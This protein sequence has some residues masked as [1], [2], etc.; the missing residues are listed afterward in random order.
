MIFDRENQD[1]NPSTATI[2]LEFQS[3]EV[4]E[5]RILEYLVGSLKKLEF[6]KKGFCTAF[7]PFCANPKTKQKQFDVAF[8]KRDFLERFSPLSR[9]CLR[10]GIVWNLKKKESFR[11]FLLFR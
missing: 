8:K 1:K 11:R 9:I 5:Q 2:N 7:S 4:Q 6:Q 3:Q 10:I